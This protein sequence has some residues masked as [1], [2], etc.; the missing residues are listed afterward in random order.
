[1]NEISTLIVSNSNREETPFKIVDAS[2]RKNINIVK[3]DINN[4]ISGTKDLF[5]ESDKITIPPNTLIDRTPLNILK[6]CKGTYKIALEIRGMTSGSFITPLLYFT[7]DFTENGYYEFPQLVNIDNL[8]QFQFM[9]ENKSST[10]TIEIIPHAIPCVDS[11]ELSKFVDKD[12]ELETRITEIENSNP[13]TS[14]VSDIKIKVLTQSEYDAIETKD[15][16]TLYF[17]KE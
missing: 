8:I 10:D 3:G 9:G 11:G 17:I 2:A 5:T 6:E 12:N 13:V 15:T 7:D 16:T 14:D 1:M 4:L